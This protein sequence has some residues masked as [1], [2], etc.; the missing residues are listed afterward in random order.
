MAAARPTPPQPEQLPPP[1]TTLSN[2][3]RPWA[4]H[5]SR[6]G[7]TSPA[8]AA[9]GSSSPA[10]CA[11]LSCDRP[12]SPEPASN[13][14]DALDMVRSPLGPLLPGGLRAAV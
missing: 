3:A 10:P 6:D 13:A 7:A 4:L 1:K 9:C 2:P 12:H 14:I 11:M 5:I 8:P